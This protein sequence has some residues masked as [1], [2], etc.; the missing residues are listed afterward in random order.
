MDEYKAMLKTQQETAKRINDYA[1][2]STKKR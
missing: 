1:F 2:S